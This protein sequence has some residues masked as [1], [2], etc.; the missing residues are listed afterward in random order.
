MRENPQ[1]HSP[2]EVGLE[3]VGFRDAWETEVLGDWDEEKGGRRRS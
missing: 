3:L 1:G 2:Y